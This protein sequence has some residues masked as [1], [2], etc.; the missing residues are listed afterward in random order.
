[1]S[2]FFQRIRPAVEEELRAAARCDQIPGR[3]LQGFHHLERA[4]VLGQE[5]TVLHVRVH[6]RMLLWAVRNRVP[7][8]FWGQLL[9]ITGA[10]TK[11]AIG[12]IPTGNT[13]GSNVSP[14]KPMQI[15]GDL[16]EILERAKS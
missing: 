3:H 14:I 7:K 5:S 2:N 8:E 4:H 16:Q 6:V 9:R 11:T 15:A 12:W 10:A 1:M 13:G